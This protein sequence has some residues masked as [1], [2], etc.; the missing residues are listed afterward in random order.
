MVQPM[1]RCTSADVQAPSF[2][3]RSFFENRQET[4]RTVPAPWSTGATSVPNP[5][6]GSLVRNV[7]FEPPPATVRNSSALPVTVGVAGNASV[8][9]PLPGNG[10]YIPPPVNVHHTSRMA[11]P[12]VTT[13]TATP[14]PGGSTPY[15]PPP[16]AVVTKTPSWVPP[17]A[18]TA[19][20]SSWVPPP[21]TVQNGSWVPPPAPVVHN[22]SWVPPPAAASAAGVPTPAQGQGLAQH[23]LQMKQ[24]QAG[25]FLQ[26]RCAADFNP[27]KYSIG[28][29]VSIGS[30]RFRCTGIL[31]RGS[32]SEVWSGEIMG[33]K[34]YQEVALKDIV[35][36]SHADLQQALFEANLLNTLLK[37]LPASPRQGYGH[38]H[39]M[40]IP[41]YL[42]HRVD[43]QPNGKWHVRMAMTRMPGEP[44]DVFLKQPCATEQDGPNAV[45]CGC[46]L[47][48]QLIRQ[49]GPTLE[50]IGH[51]AWHRDVNAHNVLVS[52]ALTGGRLQM[53]ADPEEIAARAAFWLIDFGLAVESRSWAS[54]W[55]TSDIA[56]D[57]RYWPTSS[58]MVSFYGPDGIAPHKDLI[59]QYETRLD[60]FGLGITAL[61][62]ICTVALSHSSHEQGT[63]NLRG[64][65]RRLLTAWSKYRED[66]SR[67]HTRIYHVFAVGGD[68]GPL[69]QQLAQ[70][71]VVEKV[72]Q[73]VA[74]L[75][76]CLRACT[77]RVQDDKIK[78]LLA[79]LAEMLEEGSTLGMQQAIQQ[80]SGGDI[81][82]RSYSSVPQVQS[83][84]ASRQVAAPPQSFM[85]VAKAANPIAYGSTE[86][87]YAANMRWCAPLS[88]R[89]NS[90]SRSFNDVQTEQLGKHKYKPHGGHPSFAGA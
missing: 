5:R 20:N 37:Q 65:W 44:L 89:G 9:H 17:P 72:L 8:P 40:R 11:Q 46:A 31:G 53:C 69:Y 61:E 87:A 42:A 48:A 90:R 74:T 25:M 7:S 70:E 66:V 14:L 80:I 58:W 27:E 36:H 59:H 68:I 34:D 30:L 54:A 81:S 78:A 56:G 51:F 49:L 16:L 15:A 60:I 83:F 63:D 86:D 13:G 23:A 26:G 19:G 79:V 47:A 21:A 64:S 24:G 67:W 43:Q 84:P 73:R 35:C 3:A 77:K 6:A 41:R 22:G 55:P 88:G 1:S 18:N 85:L 76:T 39:G 28:T 38:S 29:E 75:R 71:R 57:C 10:S 50:Q 45:R 12:A 4:P 52:D 32:F 33:S 82:Q 2:S 62:L